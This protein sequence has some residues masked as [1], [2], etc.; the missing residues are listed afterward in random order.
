MPLPDFESPE[1]SLGDCAICMEDII[2]TSPLRRR[3]KSLDARGDWEEKGSS[4]AGRKGKGGLLNAMHMGVGGVTARKSY[5]LAPCHHLF[6]SHF[7]ENF[8][9]NKLTPCYLHLYLVH[10][11]TDCLEKVRYYTFIIYDVC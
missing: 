9:P 1:Q 3:S 7:F 4:A 10:Q 6:V 2:I 5:S 11:H 8:A